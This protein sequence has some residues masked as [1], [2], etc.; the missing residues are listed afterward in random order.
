MR[1][2]PQQ[3][4]A[5]K[6]ARRFLVASSACVIRVAERHARRIGAP[7]MCRPHAPLLAAASKAFEARAISRHAERRQPSNP[8]AL[9]RSRSLAEPD[10]FNERPTSLQQ[11]I[12][13]FNSAGRF[14]QRRGP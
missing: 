10:G 7:G 4:E 3:R 1:S 14:D 11:R 6:R 8:L 9:R 2:V 5:G 13:R 12:L